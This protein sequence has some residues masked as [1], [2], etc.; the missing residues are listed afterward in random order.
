MH[1]SN[2]VEAGQIRMTTEPLGCTDGSILPADT[3]VTVVEREER[4]WLVRAEDG[5]EAPW[6]AGAQ[7]GLQVSS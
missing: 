5:R 4:G 3:L 6:V 7:L 1:F 2:I